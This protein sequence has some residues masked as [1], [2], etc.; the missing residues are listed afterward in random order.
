[1]ND[2][3]LVLSQ[4]LEPAE[5]LALRVRAFRLGDFGV[6]Y[7]SYHAD[8][9][10]RAQFPDRDDYIRYAW[11]HLRRDFRIRSCRVLGARQPAS[12]E[13]HLIFHQIVEVAD[14]LVETLEMARFFETEEGWRY[15]SSQKME[16]GEFSGAP[17]AIRFVDFDRLH[18]KVFF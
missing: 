6:I 8:S 1:M 15:H 12:D 16:H 2:E 13:Y 17:E 14:G 10:F 7:D 18:P 5:I 11:A 3:R 4:D 9:F